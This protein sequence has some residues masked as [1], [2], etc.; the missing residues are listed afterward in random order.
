LIGVAV[1]DATKE[2]LEKQTGLN[3]ARQ[4]NFLARL[5][6]YGVKAENFRREVWGKKKLLLS[7]GL[8]RNTSIDWPE[9]MK[10]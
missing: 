2:A 4:R 5:E 9:R 3:P 6:R 7:G 1:R 8:T 10:W